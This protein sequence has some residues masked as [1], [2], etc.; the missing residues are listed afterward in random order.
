MAAPCNL[1]LLLIQT[2]HAP[3]RFT[4]SLLRG[5]VAAFAPESQMPAE[6]KAEAKRPH[7]LLI[8]ERNKTACILAPTVLT[9]KLI[10]F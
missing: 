8:T 10:I 1:V 7:A 9:I 4:V 2:D 3:Q 5:K 6:S